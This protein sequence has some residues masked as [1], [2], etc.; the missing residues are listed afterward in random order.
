MQS[1]RNDIGGLGNLLF[2]EA[3]IYAMFRRGLV[4]DIYLQNEI[5]FK[6]YKDELKQRW[7]KNIG[8]EDKVA[9]HVRRGDYVDNPFYVDLMKTDYYE[10]A[11]KEFPEKT[12]YIFSDDITWCKE[13]KIFEG[14]VFSEGHTEIEDFNKMASCTGHII[15]NSSYSYWAAYISPNGGKVVAPKEWHPDKVER[16]VLPAEWIRI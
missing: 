8:K 6:E 13:Q 4:P 15:A 12:F 16:T 5:F 7:G 9:I 11:M 10:K 2:K 1:I 3:F 14:C